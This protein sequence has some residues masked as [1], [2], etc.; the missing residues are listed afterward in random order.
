MR[1]EAFA[2]L[3]VSEVYCPGCRRAVPVRRRL[4]LVLPEGDKI[5]YSCTVCAKPLA[6][7]VVPSKEQ[8]R[9]VLPR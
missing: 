3:E 2:D 1:E 4:L 9:F 7:K 6:S 5:E 8:V